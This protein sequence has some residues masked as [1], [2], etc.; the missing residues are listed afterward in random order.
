M[1]PDQIRQKILDGAVTLDELAA[2]AKEAPHPRCGLAASK[3]DEP[4]VSEFMCA[5]RERCRRHGR[6]GALPVAKEDERG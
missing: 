3:A 1:T 6:C 2:A 4:G 5:D